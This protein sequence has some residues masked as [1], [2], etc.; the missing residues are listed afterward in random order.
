MFT[1]ADDLLDPRVV[2]RQLG[3]LAHAEGVLA[4][5]LVETGSGELVAEQRNGNV[6]LD[7][8]ALACAQALRARIA[9]ARRL[10]LEQVDEM[11]ITAGGQQQVVRRLP[12]RPG[13]FLLALLDPE[14]ANLAL[15]R[16]HMSQAQK[17]LA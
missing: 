10:G 7:A 15:A 11:T 14:R 2:E 6:E 3:R 5:A 9:A 13:L 17:N 8:A 1:C 4:C 12:E 16:L